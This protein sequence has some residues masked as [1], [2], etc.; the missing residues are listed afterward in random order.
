MGLARISLNLDPPVDDSIGSSRKIIAM[1]VA[2]KV[3]ID[4]VNPSIIPHLLSECIK[5]RLR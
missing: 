5:L 4:T 3:V 2:A 1:T